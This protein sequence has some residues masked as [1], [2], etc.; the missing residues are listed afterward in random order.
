VNLRRIL[1]AIAA[2]AVIAAM[3]AGGYYYF[4][5]MPAVEAPPARETPSAPEEDVEA[6][7]EPPMIDLSE[8]GLRVLGVRT[9]L[10]APVPMTRVIRAV[11]RREYD[12]KRLYTVN[13]KI[14]GWIER[15]YV[16]YTGREVR[17]GEKMAEIYSP[18]LLSTQ[19]EFLD[20]LQWARSTGKG[21]KDGDALD[22]LVHKD[23]HAIIEAARKR[24]RLWD[25]SDEQIKRIERTRKP[26]RTV[27]IHSPVSGYVVEKMAIEGM[28]VMPGEKLFNVADLSTLWVIA[29]I[30]ES[31]MSL[32]REGMHAR[33]TLGSMPGVELDSRVDYV[34]P[35]LSGVTRTL[36]VRFEVPNEA[37]SLKPQMFT[38][39]EIHIDMGERLAIPETAAIETGQRQVVYVD[40][41]DG[42]FEPR[43]I[44]GGQRA[45]G[46]IEVIEGL[47]EGEAVA[48]SA[49]FLL[50]SEAQLRGVRPL[51]MPMPINAGN[52]SG[53]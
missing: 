28:K 27:T 52:S 26:M 2:V 42:Y 12:E 7:A 29:E 44:R 50:D 17:K 16:N 48:S 25:I 1:I 46:M 37:G 3:G 5:V 38:D 4:V 13:T 43:E 41:G 14:E 51:P 9:A 36:S 39:I 40:R 18:E 15:L 21:P 49:A 30:Y 19:Q 20:T 22:S 45:G 35:S 10:A 32:V 33:I 31:E 53:R 34:Y 6:E 8:E 23:A 47:S 24:L 11:G